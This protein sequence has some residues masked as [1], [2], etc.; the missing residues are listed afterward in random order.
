MKIKKSIRRA[1]AIE[2]HVHEL[3]NGELTG[4]SLHKPSKDQFDM[5]SHLYEH[6]E[7]TA[8][9]TA[10]H[11]FGDHTHSIRWQGKIVETSGPKPVSKKPGQEWEKMD[12]LQR[13]G[14]HW[15]VRSS[16]GNVL[17]RSAV[18]KDCEDYLK[19]FSGK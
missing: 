11:N 16:T 12:S 1:D 14:S 13:E 8:E 15:V 19:V 2:D 17:K 18:K 4:G 3:P 10:M 6:N 5:H 9:T 7:D